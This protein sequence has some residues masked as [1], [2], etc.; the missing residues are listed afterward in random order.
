MS[1]RNKK[2]NQYEV[3][4]MLASHLDLFWMGTMEECL[5]TGAPEHWGKD[6]GSG[7]EIIE[8]A[9]E[10]AKKNEEYYFFIETAIFADSFL[11][12]HPRRQKEFLKLCKE[13]KLEIG[14]VYV[15]RMEHIHGGESLIRQAVYG[16]RWVKENIGKQ[17]LYV[18]HPDLP[19]L[20][21]QIPQIYTKA[22][23]KG[24]L[25]ARGGAREDTGSI[26][27]WQALDGSQIIYCNVPFGYSEKAV[28]IEHMQQIL[29]NVD[30]GFPPG[31][32]I[33]RGGYG[34][35][36]MP[37]DNIFNIVQGLRK[38]FPDVSF[39]ICSPVE[40]ISVYEKAN[41][42]V[43]EGEI[44]IGWG[45]APALVV[46]LFQQSNKLENLLLSTEKFSTIA[47]ILG[48]K[49]IPDNWTKYG[50][51]G[52]GAGYGHL[53]GDVFGN[54]I[55]KGKELYSF[56]QFELVCQ[57]HNYVGIHGSQTFFDKFKMRDYALRRTQDILSTSLKSIG[58]QLPIKEKAV[59]LICFNPL[60]WERS[61]LISIPLKKSEDSYKVT[62]S[63]GKVMPTQISNGQLFFLTSCPA[64]G[65]QTFYLCSGKQ[66]NK[67]NLKNKL[68]YKELLENR[69][70]KLAIDLKGGIIASIFDKKLKKELIEEKEDMAFG[71]LISYEDPESCV[72][73]AFTGKKTRSKNINFT[74]IL[75]E[76]GI[77]FSK[78]VLEGIFL[79]AKVEKEIILYHLYRRIDLKVRIF[80]WGKHKEHIRLSLPFASKGFKSTYYGV[81][82]GVMKWP[83]MM[84]GIPKKDILNRGGDELFPDDRKHFRDAMK[85]LDV[86]YK[87]Y[88]II[89]ATQWTPVRIDGSIIEPLLLRTQYSCNDAELWI[90]NPGK[91]E[92]SFSLF[93]HQGG[94]RQ[95]KS[96]QRGWEINTPLEYIIPKIKESTNDQTGNLPLTMSFFNVSPSNVIITA[97]KKA[98]NDKGIIIRLLETKGH[99]TMATITSFLPIVR[100]KDVDLLEENAKSLAIKD[101]NVFVRLRGYEFKTLK[102]I[103]KNKRTDNNVHCIYF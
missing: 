40:T 39:K 14:G 25:H 89:V 87:N 100:G 35:L 52:L 42:P 48:L 102:I 3:N 62:N 79:D 90:E 65:Y 69:F 67:E 26:R 49:T 2:R 58:E 63:S 38:K 44:P 80:W 94:W 93:P 72:R 75:K 18:M 28:S 16:V 71:E 45:S 12:K 96:Y 60:S 64:M 32:I 8:K 57:D 86:G 77:L 99:L 53:E 41:L 36:Q 51:K 19:G 66:L 82:F 7:K 103:L 73:Y 83:E 17:P 47:D 74:L 101:K 10:L 23:I 24:Y 33:I 88:G 4:I 95:G 34:D 70:F 13:G 78:I 27:K 20:S 31:K 50:N 43:I 22:G 68:N 91:H 56:W 15:D 84:K 29:D 9:M 21:P 5:E 11:K 98:Y 30:K 54:L 59:A 1:T 97:L 76:N 61:E 46:K 55:P 37:R 92:W 81:P 85:W 6:R